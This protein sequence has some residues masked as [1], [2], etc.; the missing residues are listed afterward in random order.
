[1]RRLR[2]PA[3]EKT[4]P[5]PPDRIKPPLKPWQ[6]VLAALLLPGMGQV[7]NNMP[8]RALTMVLFL[9]FL[10]MVSYHLTTEQHSWAGRH[11][12]GIFVYGVMVMDAYRWA[13]YR[14][15]IFFRAQSDP[16]P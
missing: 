13:R 14:W 11:A 5:T 4:L 12:G 9:V 6:V 1:M 10:A 7:L 3:P 8:Q 2:L 15:E 16:Q